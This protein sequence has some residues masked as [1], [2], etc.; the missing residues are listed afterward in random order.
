MLTKI[1]LVKN[2]RSWIPI[3]FT[4]LSEL[5][6]RVDEKKLKDFLCPAIED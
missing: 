1:K 5:G 3:K 6:M 4:N 2:N